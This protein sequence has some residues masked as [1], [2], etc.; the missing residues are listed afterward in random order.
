MLAS[1]SLTCFALPIAA[2]SSSGPSPGSPANN[3][4]QSSKSESSISAIW[5]ADQAA[6]NVPRTSAQFGTGS[7][8]V[9]QAQGV[10]V[11]LNY[12]PR[13]IYRWNDP[14]NLWKG[15]CG[16]YGPK[17]YSSVRITGLKGH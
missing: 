11:E 9:R 12:A 14:S 7:E 2:R 13:D 3:A 10:S 5:V 6:G 15:Q 16:H 17:D 4:R 8:E 1:P